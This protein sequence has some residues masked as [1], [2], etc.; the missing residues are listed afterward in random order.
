MGMIFLPVQLRLSNR[1]IINQFRYWSGAFLAINLGFAFNQPAFG[2]SSLAFTNTSN[3]ICTDAPIIGKVF[4][5]KNKDGYADTGEIGIAGVRLYTVEGLQVTT[6]KNGQY[7]IAC[8]I[9][10]LKK[11][12]SNFILKID[13]K[14]LPSNHHLTSENPRVI[15]LTSSKARKV[16]FGVAQNNIITL[17][18]TDAAFAS[19]SDILKSEFSS[20]LLE[21]IDAL[22]QQRSTLRITYY[23]SAERDQ[24]RIRKLKTQI[25]NLWNIHGDDYH[26]NIER[27]TVWQIEN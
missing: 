16:N 21:V 24:T 26:L 3:E 2:Q 10:S 19:D 9:S 1:R 22:S 20:Q 8:P 11:I 12:G 25:Q 14:S 18:F 13:D 17:E 4:E 5:D 7:H 15:R 6:D 27:K 23:A